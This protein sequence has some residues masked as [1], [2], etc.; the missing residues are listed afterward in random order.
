MTTTAR[1]AEGQPRGRTSQVLLVAGLCVAGAVAVATL[2]ASL[3]GDRS[4]A[5]GALAGGSIAWCFLLFGSLVVEVAIRIA[6]QAAMLMALLT[7][8]L[9]VLLVA[10]VF[11]VLTSSGTLD[12]ALSRGWLAGGVVAATLAWTA[13][14]LITT[15]KTRIPVYDIV[16]PEPARDAPAT[17]RSASGPSSG[18]ASGTSSRAREVGAP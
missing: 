11:V 15:V 6:P 2:V 12:T 4:D 14:Q 17:T 7:Y 5:L 9:Q 16:L 10:V 13:A 1:P 18:P 8:T 3:T